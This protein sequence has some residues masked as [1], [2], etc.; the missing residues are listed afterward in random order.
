ML[1][2][3]L[4]TQAVTTS[5][6]SA[7]HRWRIVCPVS[8]VENLRPRSFHQQQS[9]SGHPGSDSCVPLLRCAPP[10]S[11]TLPLR[12]RR[13]LPFSGGVVR[14]LK[15]MAI[16]S[17]S[18]FQPT[19]RA[20]SSLSSTLRLVW[21]FDYVV[22]TTSRTPLQLTIHWLQLPQRVDFKV[23]VMAFHALHGSDASVLSYLNKLALVPD[24]PG[25]RRLRSSSPP[26]LFVPPFRLTTHC[27][28]T[29]IFSRCITTVEFTATRRPV[30]LA[31]FHL[32]LKSLVF[33]Q[34]FSDVLP[35]YASVNFEIVLLLYPH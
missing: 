10:A 23:A 16:F 24:L 9:R 17:W 34:S 1:L 30:T 20:T 2:S 11:S 14:A 27:W 22:T 31:V 7:L 21:C 5:Q 19:Y 4:C 13:L 29:L 32:R 8:V 25:R 26:Q 3:V 12:H 18:G 6:L 28:S 33:R 35:W 15:T